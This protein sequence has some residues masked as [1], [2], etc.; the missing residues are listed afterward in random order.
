MSGETSGGAP[1]RPWWMLYLTLLVSGLLLLADAYHLMQLD[2]WTA[3]FGV[4]LIYAAFILF[5]GKGR[6]PSYISAGIVC[7]AVILTFVA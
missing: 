6:P 7:L 1:A 2:R 3:K 5:V 4:A